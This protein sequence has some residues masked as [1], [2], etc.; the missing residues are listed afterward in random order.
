MI[1]KNK[2]TL[3]LNNAAYIGMCI[4]EL[5]KVLKYK[6]NY[7]YLK[8]NTAATRDYYLQTMIV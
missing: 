1:R 5:N 3:T 4:L 2:V 8:I 6:F 7:D